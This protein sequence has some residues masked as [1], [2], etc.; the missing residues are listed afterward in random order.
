MA[1]NNGILIHGGQHAYTM[2]PHNDKA[3]GGYWLIIC[4]NSTLLRDVRGYIDTSNIGV[5]F[6]VTSNIGLGFRV[7]SNINNS[8]VEHYINCSIMETIYHNN[9]IIACNINMFIIQ[10]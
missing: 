1:P 8:L 10:Y 4:K 2:A 7:S 3:S 5:G 9:D 6:E